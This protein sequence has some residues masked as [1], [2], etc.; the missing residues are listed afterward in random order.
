MDDYMRRVLPLALLVLAPAGLTAQTLLPMGDTGMGEAGSESPAEFR[1][2]VSEAG[3]LTVV[4]RGADESDLRIEVTDEEGQTL[5]GGR[6][7]ADLNGDMGAEQLVVELPRGGSYRVFV[8]SYGMDSSPFAV[9]GSFLPS[10][11]AERATDPD[12]RPS[13]AVRVDIG[14]LHEDSLDPAR[15]DRWDWFAFTPHESGSLTVLTRTE[16]GDL[17]IEIFL[18]GEYREP[19]LRVDDDQEGVLGNESATV[20]VRAGQSVYVKVAHPF[21]QGSAHGYRLRSGLIPG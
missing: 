14:E 17:A 8:E 2:Q 20:D 16:E 21:E 12:G 10:R 3:F 13:D 9:G 1:L 19:L 15:G 18:E 4:V 5:L 7:D 11:L 6:A